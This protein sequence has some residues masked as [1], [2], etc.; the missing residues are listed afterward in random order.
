MP[1]MIDLNVILDVMQ[2]REPHYP[3]SA[4][5]LNRIVTGE[6]KAYVPAHALTTLHYIL[7]KYDSKQKANESIDWL[8][9]YFQVAGEEKE[10]FLQARILS[11]SNCQKITWSNFS[12]TE[13]R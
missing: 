4:G 8:L 2:K 6:F 7:T 9:H 11:L 10:V 3:A 13:C 1:I 5:V 12:A